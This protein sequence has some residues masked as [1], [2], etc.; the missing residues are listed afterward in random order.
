MTAYCHS[1]Y[2]EDGSSFYWKNIL[3]SDRFCHTTRFPYY[4]YMMADSRKVTS[5][6]DLNL[7][8]YLEQR[9]SYNSFFDF[10]GGD[11]V[12]RQPRSE[13]I[14]SFWFQLLQTYT[15]QDVYTRLA[16]LETE[17]WQQHFVHQ[18]ISLVLDKL[19]FPLFDV[20]PGDL[21]HYPCRLALSKAFIMILRYHF[22]E[23]SPYPYDYDRAADMP[24][25]LRELVIQSRH[26]QA[27]D[28]RVIREGDPTNNVKFLYQPSK[29]KKKKVVAVDPKVVA[30]RSKKITKSHKNTL[31]TKDKKG[32]FKGKKPGNVDVSPQTGEN[33]LSVADVILFY[34]WRTK[35]FP[36][37]LDYGDSQGQFN[38]EDEAAHDLA[39]TRDALSELLGVD[40]G[41]YSLV[42]NQQAHPAEAL[43]EGPRRNPGPEGADSLY[44]VFAGPHQGGSEP[45]RIPEEREHD[46][47]F[48]TP[49]EFYEDGS[50]YYNGR[51]DM[52]MLQQSFASAM[53]IEGSIES[54]EKGVGIWGIAYTALDQQVLNASRDKMF[55]CFLP[56]SP[57]AERFTLWP[58]HSLRFSSPI[59]SSTQGSFSVRISSEDQTV[60]TLSALLGSTSEGSQAE[61]MLRRLELC[62]TFLHDSSGQPQGVP[63]ARVD[64][65]AATLAV[66]KGRL[67]FSTKATCIAKQFGQASEPADPNGL[68]LRSREALL[69][70]ESVEP[71]DAALTMADVLAVAGLETAEWIKAVVCTIRVE[72]AGLTGQDGDAGPGRNGLWLSPSSGLEAILRLQFRLVDSPSL[73]AL[74]QVLPDNLTSDTQFLVTAKRVALY[75]PSGTTIELEPEVMLQTTIT[76][77]AMGT[78][79]D[80]EP[81]VSAYIFLHEHS[82][83]LRL[84]RHSAQGSMRNLF[85]WIAEK[86]QTGGGFGHSVTEIQAAMEKMAKTGTTDLETGNAGFDISWRS[87]SIEF[88][89]SSV[90]EIQACFELDMALGVPQG[91]TAGF[92]LDFLWQP[93]RW[94]ISAAFMPGG[95]EYVRGVD[96][97]MDPTWEFCDWI[98]PLDLR[99]ESRMSLLHLAPS[100]VFKPETV[101]SYLPTDICLATLALSSDG[102]EFSALL[103]SP[104]STVSPAP[105]GQD[106]PVVPLTGTSLFISTTYAPSKGATGSSQ[107]NL[108]ISGTVDLPMLEQ[109]DGSATET[110]LSNPSRSSSLNLTV[111]YQSQEGWTFAAGAHNICIG[112][113]VSSV[114]GEVEQEDVRD[115]L[116]HLVLQTLTLEYQHQ[117]ARVSALS[118]TA[119]LVF[120]AY[121][122]TLTYNR[123]AGDKESGWTLSLGLSSRESKGEMTVGS[124]LRW[125]LGD[126]VAD[127]LPDFIAETSVDLGKTGFGMTF[128]SQKAKDGTSDF[129]LSAV[130]NLGDLICIQ[131]ARLQTRPAGLKKG[132]AK[133]PAK[134]LLRVGIKS[135]PRPPPLPLVGQIDPVFSVDFRWVNIDLLDK[136]VRALND[137]DAFKEHRL[138]LEEEGGDTRVKDK[139][140]YGEGVSFML[141]AGGV[142]V[143]SSRPKSKTKKKKKPTGP[144]D[145]SGKPAEPSTTTG[146]SQARPPPEMKPFKK[147]VNGVS[148]TNV[149]LDYD[150]TNQEVQIRFTARATVGP[151]DGELINFTMKVAMPRSDKKGIQLSDWTNLGI[152][153][154]MDGLALAMTGRNLAL[155]GF[156]ERVKEKQEGGREV[157]G[158]EGGIGM[159]IKTYAFTAF[160]SYREV[161]EKDG[162]AA[163][164]SLM[165]YAM[166]QGPILKTPYV[167]IRGLCGGFG[168]G[169]QLTLPSVTQVRGFPLLMD[170]TASAADTFARLRGSGPGGGGGPRYMTEVDGATWF[171]VGVLATAFETVDVSAVV[172]LAMSPEVCEMGIVG[173]AAARFPRGEAPDKTLALI[174]LNFEG[175]IDLAHGFFQFQGQISERSFL[176]SSDCHPT[177]GFVVATWFGPSPT[178]GDWCISIGGWH[179]AFAPPA[180]YPSAPPRLGIAWRYSSNLAI[181]GQ[182]YAAVTPDMLMGGAALSALFSVGPVG[183]HFDFR[184]DFILQMHPLHYQVTVHVSAGVWYELTIGPIRKKISAGLGAELEL[185]GPPFAGIVRFDV[186]VVTIEVAFGEQQRIAPPAL[187]LEAFVDVCLQRTKVENKDEDKD[188]HADHVLTLESG[189]VPPATSP[190][191][192]Q[193]PDT[194]WVVRGSA[195]AFT[196]VSRIPAS[197]I[198]LTQGTTPAWHADRP[199]LARPMQL[200]STSAGLTAPLTI[201]I[202][203]VKSD[204]DLVAGAGGEPVVES[205]FKFEPIIE[206]VPASLWGEYDQNAD[207]ML[208]PA[209]REATVPHATGV[210]IV[211]AKTGWSEKNPRIVPLAKLAPPLPSSANFR[212]DPV[213]AQGHD[214]RA[215]G[216]QKVGGAD[217]RREEFDRARRAMLGPE[218]D[219]QQR[220]PPSGGGPVVTIPDADP[221]RSGSRTHNQRRAAILAQWA[222]TR[223]LISAGGKDPASA[224]LK[225]KLGLATQ[226]PLRYVAGLERFCHVPPRVTVE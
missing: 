45:V 118:L 149:G 82:I 122:F 12:G 19:F 120:K 188:L 64:E 35:G 224:G 70:L 226:V 65:M 9:G 142:P 209:G 154:D 83:E 39:H 145:P 117:G 102:I 156:L 169:S 184:A 201:T 61:G 50:W 49:V 225:D 87:F 192:A 90:L 155:A 196:V 98:P 124:I 97:H 119:V 173:T 217:G 14:S 73:S 212:D 59:Q 106:V 139:V 4:F 81:D 183:A 216:V 175:R 191:G 37:T 171:A 132:E 205:G 6:T 206:K 108:V 21:I 147:R 198:E 152:S 176:L 27:L 185:S 26:D 42:Y 28:G 159:T 62:C 66:G 51:A 222:T 25:E 112:S 101:P 24:Q 46:P 116:G 109:Q 96:E 219:E 93:R 160:G 214:A 30:Q 77:P 178:A 91:K 13:H 63:A 197:T 168:V 18:N 86:F 221:G 100:G 143:L 136:E 10:L 150:D 99:R 34:Q 204:S 131:F 107:F 172:T 85:A 141:L 200:P 202:T 36:D 103:K 113:L 126:S 53:A 193:K 79:A 133:P 135:L 165:A 20:P 88:D 127:A 151:L 129:T 80:K 52:N 163:F 203:R 22:S 215:R 130:L 199:I 137:R 23:F 110:G 78:A 43:V 11:Y 157:V 60:G 71:E 7:K 180:H 208:C 1:R 84:V 174:E 190:K 48:A 164:A 68:Q 167:E 74:S 148:I 67:L 47:T 189:G 123:S 40:D 125:V 55:S 210:R 38:E 57:D 166:L 54:N 181:T 92:S 111:K 56:E 94:K 5:P 211:P 121:A 220:Q 177:G 146:S 187:G 31:R 2:R 182:A 32:G 33:L 194:P 114:F 195:L 223:G 138:L 213:R 75:S 44:Y 140:A 16:S 15:P 41:R 95:V 218:D 17:Y 104:N 128:T 144:D 207:T 76:I 58:G 158:F 170:A 3:G 115:V 105:S 89:S 162:T 29:P 179:P 186:V 72:L 69:A 153:L 161:T 134:M 8:A